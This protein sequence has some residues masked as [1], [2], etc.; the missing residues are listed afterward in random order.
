MRGEAEERGKLIKAASER[1]ASPD[2]ACEL[3]R[4]F[5]QSEI[6]LIK[7]VEANAARCGITPEV[8]DQLRVG[9][10][11]TTV[12]QNMV[13]A[14]ARQAQWRGPAGPVGDFDDIGAPPLVR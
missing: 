5:G 6:N 1:R 7:Y 3:I 2:E 11:K 8:A 10:R 9:H 13:C 4:N 12:R 14:V